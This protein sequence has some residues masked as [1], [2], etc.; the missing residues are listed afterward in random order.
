MVDAGQEVRTLGD[1]VRVVARRKWLIFAVAVLL[2]IA[3]VLYSLQRLPLY[4]ASAEVLL[5]RTTLIAEITGTAEPAF[6]QQPDRVAKTQAGVA[7]VPAVAD[8]VLDAA[9]I[10][11][12]TADEFLA[13]SSVTAKP[14]A[15][16]L[17]L[18]V[19][20]G[21]PRRAE[22]L[23]TEYA[24]Q[25]TKYRKELD[26]AAIRRA[27]RGLEARLADLRANEQTRTPLYS[28]L[29]AKAQQLRTAEALATGNT[30]VIREAAE[31]TK[32]QPR[33]VRDAFLAAGLGLLLGV[34]AAFFRDAL[35]TRIRS[36][37]EISERLGVPL[38]AR[39]PEPPRRLRNDRLVMLEDPNRPE[40]EAFRMLRTNLDF[41]N[42]ERGARTIMVTSASEGE[43]KSTTVSNLAIAL[44][45]AGQGVALV[46]L[47]LRRP[48][49]QTL[50]RLEGRPGLTHVILEQATLEQALAKIAISKSDGGRGVSPSVNGGEG[51]GHAPVAGFLEVLTSGPLPPDPGEFVATRAL[52]QVLDRLRAR[53]DFVLLDAPPLLG[54]GDTM[55]ISPNVDGI[56]VVTR[57][58]LLRRPLLKELHRLLAACPAAT[59]GFAVTGAEAEDGYGYGFD[60]YYAAPAPD[61][62]RERVR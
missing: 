7:A 28:S 24:R 29:Q 22:L 57:M 8:R 32:V 59:L 60:A 56:V 15:D 12:M 55:A 52:A 47:D 10:T 31:A 19:D 50:F 38:L 37:D 45:R 14:D 51:N 44:A 36:A 1:Y 4:R 25:F 46:D 21:D 5:S 11:D 48:S 39:I 42:L 20:A 53:A 23:A 62:R 58:N 40:A 41:V 17:V 3:A 18:S 33:P 35:D 34:L 49:I 61:R 43:G 9:G 27:R 6:N 54:V 13:H 26:T 16:L 30:S 2:P